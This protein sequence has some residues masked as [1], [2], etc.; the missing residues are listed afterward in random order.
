[1][2]S[3]RN[4]VTFSQSPARYDLPPP[5]LDEHGAELRAWLSAPRG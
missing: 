3:V 5:G 4:P 2:P 1:V